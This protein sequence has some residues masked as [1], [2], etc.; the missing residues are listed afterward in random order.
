MC[1]ASI[2]LMNVVESEVLNRMQAKDSFTALDVSNALKTAKYPVRHREVAEIVRDIYT[3]GAM[4]YYDYDR[5]L[6][7]VTINGGTET[8]QAYLYQHQTARV[9]DYAKLHQDALP[10]VPANQARD[11]SDCVAADSLGLLQRSPTGHPIRNWSRKAAGA[12]RSAHGRQDGALA[13]SRVLIAQLG[14]TDGEQLSVRAEPGQLVVESPASVVTSSHNA[15]IVKVWSGR[16]VRICKT[17]LNL[18]GFAAPDVSVSIDGSRL[19][20][21]ARP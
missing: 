8:A 9:S 13:I 2:P 5:H 7:D 14:W 10:P 1:N 20:I 4:A 17:K 16:R 6:I 11:L 19:C 3:S 21:A 12:C 18:G 15:P